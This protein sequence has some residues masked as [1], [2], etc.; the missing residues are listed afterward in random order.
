M[1]KTSALTNTAGK[2]VEKVLILYR[3]FPETV[4]NLKKHFQSATE[5][6]PPPITPIPSKSDFGLEEKSS[7]QVG[8]V[9]SGGGNGIEI[10]QY[11]SVHYNQ[12]CFFDFQRTAIIRPPTLDLTIF[13]MNL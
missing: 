1:C 2:F 3:N 11:V 5:L 10:I 7:C 13:P 12:T 8:F 9:N 6:P 4:H